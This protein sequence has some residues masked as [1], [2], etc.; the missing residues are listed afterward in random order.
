LGGAGYR[1]IGLSRARL[2]G[3]GNGGVGLSETCHGRVGLIV[4]GRVDDR[5]AGGIDDST[6]VG[7]GRVGR[8]TDLA[9]RHRGVD[10]R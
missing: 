5:G 10:G 1:G 2:G 3:A 7:R 8:D 6:A 4:R 9:S